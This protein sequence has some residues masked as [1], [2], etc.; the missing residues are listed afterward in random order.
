[1]KLG[2]AALGAASISLAAMA[3]CDVLHTMHSDHTGQRHAPSAPTVTLA[4]LAWIESPTADQLTAFLCPR[5][6]EDFPLSA[7]GTAGCRAR[8]P[9]PMPDSLHFQLR[10]EATIA[11]ASMVRMD[12]ESVLVVLTAYPD[13]G[14]THA[15]GAVCITL[16]DADASQCPQ[17]DEA[18]RSTTDGVVELGDLDGAG[19]MLSSIA[20]TEHRL[21]DLAVRSIA[22]HGSTTM[23]IDIDVDRERLV[24]AIQLNDRAANDAIRAGQATGY[25]IPYALEGT[26]WVEGRGNDGFAE[27]MGRTTGTLEITP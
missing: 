13:A 27:P 12:V 26:L 15:L 2:T 6:A 10:A 14:G 8:G 20:V 3:G 18:C 7:D 19:G 11:N 9:T 23:T 17:T 22:P 4:P 21:A 1:M 16:C 5:L 25:S 24:H